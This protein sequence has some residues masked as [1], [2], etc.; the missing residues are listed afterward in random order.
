VRL[1]PDI[2]FAAKL[3]FEIFQAF[4]AEKR[5]PGIAVIL[6]GQVP[7]ERPHLPAPDAEKIGFRGKCGTDN[8]FPDVP[9]IDDRV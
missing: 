8:L 3:G 9:G 1:K 7:A 4:I 2:Q 6:D 5:D